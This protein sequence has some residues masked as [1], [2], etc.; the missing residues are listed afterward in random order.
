M[1]VDQ[2]NIKR[3]GSF[4]TKNNA[5]V[6]PYC[7]GPEALSITFER[8]KAIPWNIQSLRRSGGVKNRK[9]SLSRVHHVRPYTAPV[10]ALIEPFQTPVLEAPNHQNTP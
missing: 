10:A 8:V 2:F 1:V 9:D 5:P 6:G 3:V 4:K 7:H